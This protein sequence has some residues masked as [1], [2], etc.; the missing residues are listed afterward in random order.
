MEFRRVLFRSI[1]KTID[2]SR[3][4]SHLIIRD[5]NDLMSS[6]MDKEILMEVKGELRTASIEVP[7]AKTYELKKVVATRLFQDMKRICR[8][9]QVATPC[10]PAMD[11]LDRIRV[12]DRNTSTNAV[13]T[14]KGI[15]RSY[16]P[17]GGLIQFLE[18]FWSEDGVVV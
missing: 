15:R 1:E 11:V 10:N 6:F 2:F 9:L 7:W 17:E 14:I 4:R 16:S 3:A 8:T 5:E 18:L 12:Y 13:Y